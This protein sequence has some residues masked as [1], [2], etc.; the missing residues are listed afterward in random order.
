MAETDQPNPLD[1]TDQ[2]ETLEV[3][4]SVQELQLKALREHITQLKVNLAE[5]QTDVNKLRLE[6]NNFRLLMLT[7]SS[8]PTADKLYI[9]RKKLS[10]QDVDIETLLTYLEVFQAHTELAAELIQEKKGKNS[11]KQHLKDKQ[12]ASAQAVK[13]YRAKTNLRKEIG[14][15]GKSGVSELDTLDKTMRSA[16]SGMLKSLNKPVTS[17]TVVWALKSIESMRIKK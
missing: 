17:E 2:I 8:V 11:I 1:P 4:L 9:A 14:N 12:E 10:W 5:S 15:L 16:V 6:N 3:K 7:E 13:D